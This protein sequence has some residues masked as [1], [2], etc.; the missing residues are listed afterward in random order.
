MLSS[1][2]SGVEESKGGEAKCA[3]KKVVGQDILFINGSPDLYK[4]YVY[5]TVRSVSG[6]PVR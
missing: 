6:I 5:G 1:M 4:G 2:G 3:V